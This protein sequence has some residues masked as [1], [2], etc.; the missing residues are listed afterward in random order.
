VVSQ[1]TSKA[2]MAFIRLNR[3]LFAETPIQQ[4]KTTAYIYKTIYYFAHGKGEK[5]VT[6]KGVELF[7]PGEDTAIVP[8]I[9]GGYFESL[10]LD[11]FAAIATK[12]KTLLD[13]GGNIGLYSAIGLKSNPKLKLHAFEPVKQNVEYFKRNLEANGFKLS[14]QIILNVLAVGDKQGTLKLFISDGNSAI[15]SASSKHS[16]GTSSH[17]IKMTSIDAYCAG[18]KIKP[19]LL[20]IDIEGYDGFAIEGGLKTISQ[21]RPT[22]FIEYDP[23]ALENCNYK[24]QEM[25]KNLFKVYKYG[26]V[27]VEKSGSL[28]R[29]SKSE[30]LSAAVYSNM[31]LLFSVNKEHLKLAKNYLEK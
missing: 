15:H 20:K 8:S 12:S 26:Y 16:G 18:K 3:R 9:V 28:R 29:A 31:N 23:E 4:W 17:T 1:V 11:V 10:E 5:R 14:K 7:L 19:D 6:Y 2:G 27:F 13:I 21:C 30:I 25:L 22:L 24:P